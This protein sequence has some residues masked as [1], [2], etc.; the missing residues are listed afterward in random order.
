MATEEVFSRRVLFRW[1]LAAIA[2]FG[3]ALYLAAHGDSEGSSSIGPIVESRSAF[4]FAGIADILEQLE[5]PVVHTRYRSRD[6][7]GSGGVLVIAEPRIDPRRLTMANKILSAKAILLILPKWIGEESESHAGWVGKAELSPG[8]AVQAVLDLVDP[9]AE[10]QRGPMLDHW[11]HNIIGPTPVVAA[12]A[13]FI[14]SKKL[15]PI[16]SQANRILVGELTKKDQRIFVLADPDVL[17][18]HG[19]EN[20]GNAAF[21]VALLGALRTG[22]GP[23]VFDEAL[24]SAPADGLNFIHRVF[25]PPLL[26]GT[27]MAIVGAV[28]LLWATMPRFGAADPPAPALDSGKRGLIDNIASMV[29]FSGRRAAIAMRFAEATVLD[30]AR[31]LHAPRGLAGDGLTAWLTRVG[32]AR[33]VAT[34]I[35]PAIERANALTAAG[36]AD[37]A[38]LLLLARTMS[39]WKQEIIHGPARHQKRR[40]KPS[41]GDSQGDR[42]TG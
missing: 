7:L 8:L 25:E 18:N 23:V 31:Q 30:V 20:A 21:A 29:G 36:R 17:S 3:A 16:V 15:R 34:D 33:G 12:P 1:S 22:D 37:A 40:G 32:K 10:F 6:K 24:N 13:Q 5:T 28:L 41:R 9:E 42:W 11:D 38:E 4:G 27:I 26:P 2:A 35:R 39:D 19:L 14:I